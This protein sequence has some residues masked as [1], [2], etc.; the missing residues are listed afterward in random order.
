MRTREK[1]GS[2]QCLFTEWRPVNRLHSRHFTLTV[3][4]LC[5]ASGS[6]SLEV[7]LQSLQGQR[8]LKD[9]TGVFQGP[10]AP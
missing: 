9:S 10:K 6:F 5:G 1:T 4:Q 3:K 8:G 7:E 2:I